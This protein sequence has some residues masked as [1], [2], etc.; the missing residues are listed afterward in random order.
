MTRIIFMGTPAFAVPSLEALVAERYEIAAVITQPDRPAGRGRRLVAPA[1]K[2]AA[3]R[4]GLPVW[5]PETMRGEQI[6]DR[7]REAAPDAIVVAAYGEILR[8]NVLAIPPRGIVN[9]HASLLPRHRGASPVAGAL[10]AGD[11]VTGVSIML[12]DEGMDTGPILDMATLPIVPDDN[13]GTL[14]DKLAALGAEQ[15]RETLPRW[16]SEEITPQP[17]DNSQA[18]YSRLI[19]K[20]HGRVNWEEPAAQ[21]A[22]RCR[23]YTPWPG[24]F[25]T[26]QGR[27]LKI[28]RCH[29]AGVE[30]PAGQPGQVT[31]SAGLPAAVTGESLLLLD[32]VQLAGK[33]PVNATDFLRG[34]RDFAGS[35][36]L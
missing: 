19:K 30:E 9:V 33:R 10:L 23:A 32:E 3:L 24:L 34:H 11:E 20:E 18:T 26:W 15:L 8:P 35:L 4:L 13:R 21:I 16:L 28:V 6:M 12:M 36:L 17:Q 2:Q 5:Q 29:P 22:R 25:T 1:V 7:L 14:T 31:I 27:T